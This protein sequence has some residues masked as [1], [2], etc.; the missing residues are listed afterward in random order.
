[1]DVG[2][3]D[4]TTINLSLP[5]IIA[6]A[7]FIINYLTGGV[8]NPLF[9]I[10][11]LAPSVGNEQKVLTL[12]PNYRQDAKRARM[13]LHRL[14]LPWSL[15][16]EAPRFSLQPRGAQVHSPIHPVC[17]PIHQVRSPI[18]EDQ[19]CSPIHSVCSPTPR[20]QF[21]SPHTGLL[22]TCP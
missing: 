3:T 1:M 19:V 15:L 4:R 9:G 6:S 22:S 18:L 12:T 13:Y 17:S 11:S 16:P 7:A 10:I 8:R 5:F 20:N 2:H 14:I 21:C